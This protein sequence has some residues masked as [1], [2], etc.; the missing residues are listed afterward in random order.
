[1]ADHLRRELALELEEAGGVVEQQPLLGDP[2]ELGDDLR[3]VAGLD[4]G[5]ALAAAARAGEV[6]DRDRLVREEPVAH[7][8]RRERGGGLERLGGEAQ[9]VVLLVAGH[10]PLQDLE[11]LGDGRLVHHHLGEA[12]LER[13]VLRDELPELVVGGRADAGELA[14]RHRGLELVRRVLRALAGRARADQG[15]DLVDEHHHPA[16]G[17]LHLVLEAVQLLGERAA[18]L[19][20]G[21]ERRHVELDEDPVLK[22][23]ARLEQ[24]L[25]DALDDRGLADARLADEARVV[26]APL[27]EDVDDLLDLL[28]PADARVELPLAGGDR[29]VPAERG[30][31]RV[32]LGV[33]RV[34]PTQRRQGHAARERTGRAPPR[35]TG[36]SSLLGVDQLARAHRRGRRDDRGRGGRGERASRRGIRARHRR[37]R[38]RRDLGHRSPRLELPRHP[39]AQVV[40]QRRVPHRREIHAHLREQLLRRAADPGGRD[41]HVQA[42]RLARAAALGDLPGAREQLAQLA[43]R[44][45][46]RRGEHLEQPVLVDAALLEEQLGAVVD[47]EDREQRV[48]SGQLL[49]DAAGNVLG[50]GEDLRELGAVDHRLSGWGCSVE[51]YTREIPWAK[52]ALQ[53]ATGTPRGPFQTSG[54]NRLFPGAYL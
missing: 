14:A 18:E 12:P 43:V 13:R 45:E 5:L 21:D 35:T 20:A 7:V 8:A 30:E 46:R 53:R 36:S 38:G 25:G 51:V 28:R 40:G 34:G 22:P 19:G 48:R 44:L 3:D 29:E 2:G 33:E 52:F 23:A 41:Q 6:G 1:M 24:L 50:F 4:P 42:V 9:P 15:V 47:G 54:C 10:Q 31:Q 32:E 26:R 16:V 37:S 11:R 49:V 27:A 39:P 17:L